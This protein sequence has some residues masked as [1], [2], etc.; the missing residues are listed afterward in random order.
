MATLIN[1][2]PNNLST[3]PNGNATKSTTLGDANR[4]DTKVSSH[5]IEQD[6]GVEGLGAPSEVTDQSIDSVELDSLLIKMNSQLQTLQNYMKFERDESS[7]SMVVFIKD[8]ETDKV[9]RQIPTQEFL[10]ISK[11]IDDYLEMRQQLS[12]KTPP[13][14]G[15]ITN[16][17]V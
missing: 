12:E 15:M 2:Q 1:V 14:I 13:P 9:I 11:N 3:I 8:S 5:S 4:P 17:T 10:A 6:T 7:Q 16:E